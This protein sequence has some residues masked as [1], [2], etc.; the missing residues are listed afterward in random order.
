MSSAKSTLIQGGTL[1]TMDNDRQV[2][3]G[4]LRIRD[5]RIQEIAPHLSPCL[6]KPPLMPAAAL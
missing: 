4:D 1:V 3:V 6:E 5:N 2:F